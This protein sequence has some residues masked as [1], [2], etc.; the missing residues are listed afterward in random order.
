[1]RVEPVNVTFAMRGWRT[2]ASP[3]V[4]PSPC[5]T[6]KIP[7]GTPASTASSASLS[8]ENGVI[9]EGFSTTALP[10]ASAGAIFHD[11]ITSGKFHGAIAAI[12]PYGSA[13]VM[14]R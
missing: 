3:V 5:T 1:V 14:P 8:T 4:R 13:M 6:L 7:G 9:S 2:S 11:A 10:A 12:T